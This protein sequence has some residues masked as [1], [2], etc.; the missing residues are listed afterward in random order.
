M[1][2]EP[3]AVGV[4][5]EVDAHFGVFAA[6]AAHGGVTGVL[7]HFIVTDAPFR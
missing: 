3:V 2:F 6:D 7:L 1:I 5:D 4:G